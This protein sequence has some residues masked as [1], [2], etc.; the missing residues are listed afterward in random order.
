MDERRCPPRLR[1][2]ALAA[3]LVLAPPLVWPAAGGTP[4][5]KISNQGRLIPL[6]KAVR[7]ALLLHH[8]SPH[9]YLLAKSDGMFTFRFGDSGRCYGGGRAFD[10]H[11]IRPA[12]VPA[13]FGNVL[14]S[15]HR[16][17]LDF[18]SYGATR[19]TPMHLI[20]LHG[21]AADRVSRIKLLAADGSA[22][23]AVTVHHNVYALFAVPRGVESLAAV[24]WRGK[25]L[26]TV[27]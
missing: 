20:R 2:I 3:V 24:D 6:S 5:P 14:C 7:H 15:T 8:R 26:A 23:T 9:V 17:V 1:L 16:L 25:I 12:Q 19:A 10:L 21:V 4:A 27:P 18:S 22:R 11:A 13:I